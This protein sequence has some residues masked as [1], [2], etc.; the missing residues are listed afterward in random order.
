MFGFPFY[1]INF[2]TQIRFSFY[3][4]T[5]VYFFYFNLS[6]HPPSLSFLRP[7]SFLPTCL[8]VYF[9]LSVSPPLHPSSVHLPSFRP[10]YLFTST[11]LCPLPSILP[12]S[13]FLPSDMLICPQH[14]NRFQTYSLEICENLG[15]ETIFN[16][17]LLHKY[18]LILLR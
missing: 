9:N 6:V 14:R 16:F 1:N 3:Q 15:K 2:M 12:P 13:T 17:K 11:C 4:R 10:A 7:P 5:Q 18:I 8:S